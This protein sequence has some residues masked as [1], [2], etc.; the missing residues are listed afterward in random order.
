[1]ACRCGVLLRRLAAVLPRTS[2]ASVT[3]SSR[4]YAK[5]YQQPEEEVRAY[6]YFRKKMKHV[7]RGLRDVWLEQEKMKMEE[8]GAQAAEEAREER[9]LEQRALEDNR[10]E[11]ERM[12]QQRQERMVEVERKVAEKKERGTKAREA[13]EAKITQKRV[14]KVIRAQ[15]ASAEFITMENL[16]MKIKE[17]IENEV[18]YNFALSRTGETITEST[19]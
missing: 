5:K 7:R 18:N 4:G 19:H 8:F 3:Q 17:A 10:L 1:M 6:L 9:E 11:L 16:D 12:A 2:A 15:E 14:L 13:S